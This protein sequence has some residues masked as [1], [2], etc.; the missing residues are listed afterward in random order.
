MVQNGA[1]LGGHLGYLC[2]ENKRFFWGVEGDVLF[3]IGAKKTETFARE[4]STDIFNYLSSVQQRKKI[5]CLGSLRV[6]LGCPIKKNIMLYG[7]GGY[8]LGN[9][10]LR[11]RTTIFVSNP[12]GDFDRVTAEGKSSKLK[13]GWTL[14]GGMEWKCQRNLSFKFEYL[15]YRLGSLKTTSPLVFFLNVPA[16]RTVYTSADVNSKVRFAYHTVKLGLNYYCF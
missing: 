6:K 14:G 15:Y 8:A 5:D 16:A 11:T 12:P 13:S 9:V 1:L 3:P 10:S 7:T 4:N 2:A